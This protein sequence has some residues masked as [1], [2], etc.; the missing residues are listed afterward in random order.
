MNRQGRMKNIQTYKGGKPLAGKVPVQSPYEG[1][2]VIWFGDYTSPENDA[3]I[4]DLLVA[5]SDSPMI[6]ERLKICEAQ[7]QHAQGL[8]GKVKEQMAKSFRKI[9]L[10]GGAEGYATLAGFGPGGASY[11]AIVTDTKHQLGMAATVQIPGDP[12]PTKESSITQEAY[13]KTLNGG[14]EGNPTIGAELLLRHF[15]PQMRKLKNGQ[16]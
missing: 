4:I 6:T 7:Y 12:P 14:S 10:P 15:A 5:P 2:N 8:Q 13:W 11:I 3:A 16:Y 9:K 1:D